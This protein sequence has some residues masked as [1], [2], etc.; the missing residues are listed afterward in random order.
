MVKSPKLIDSMF[1][2]LLLLSYGCD[3]KE[4]IS[5][6]AQEQVTGDRLTITKFS[7]DLPATIATGEKLFVTVKYDIASVDKAQIFV[8][9]YTNGG[10]TSDYR[11]H[12]CRPIE[13]GQGEIEGYF[14]FDEPTIVNEVRVKFGL[15]A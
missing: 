4:N 6:L 13:K 14:F 2:S 3:K 8:R 5:H 12:A 7:P 10:R 15:P 9:P 1:I 11:A